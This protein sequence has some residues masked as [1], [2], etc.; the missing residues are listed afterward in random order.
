M[1]E[2]GVRVAQPVVGVL[3]GM[4]PDATVELMRRVIRATPARDDGDHIR[5]IVDNNPKVPSRI[6]ALIDGTG[7]DPGPTLSAMARGLERAGASFLV[8]PCNTAHHYLPT[9]RGAVAVPVVDMIDL[10]VARLQSLASPVRRLGLLASP[11]V[12]LTGLVESRCRKVGIE[13]LY[14]EGADDEAV[15]ALIRAVKAGQV[16]E[17]AMAVYRAAAERLQARGAEGLGIA[18]SELS[19]VGGL[20]TSYVPIIDT[21]DVLVD[22]ILDRCLGS[23]AMS[24]LR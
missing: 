16:P 22:D 20:S 1:T 2:G 19:A 15:L 5:M 6:K 8:I 18:C 21:L 4:G 7:E 12:R 23:A 13:V 24:G 14:P 9:I 10:T 3:G 17:A 11:A